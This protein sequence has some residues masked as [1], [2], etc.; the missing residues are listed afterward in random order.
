M[1]EDTSTVVRAYRERLLADPYRPGYHFCVPDGDGRPGDPN[2]CFY[3]DGRHH[4]MYLYKRDGWQY[5]WGHVSSIDLVHW[6]H[7]PDA[8]RAEAGDEGCFSGGAFVDDDG[9][10]YLSFWIYNAQREEAQA[11]GAGIG[12]ACSTPPYDEWTRMEHVAI[13]STRWGIREVDGQPVGCADPSNIWKVNGVYYIQTGNLLVLD[14]CGRAPDSPATM[15]GDWTELF[16]SLDL[17][18]WT[19][20]GRFYTRRG[21]NTWTAEDED[22][23]CP[24]FLP[25][26]SA[27]EG[28]R[29]SAHYLQLFISHNRGAQYYI[30]RYDT[31]FFSPVVHGRM[32]WTDSAFFA[33][34]AYLDDQG[35]QIMFAWLR[36]NLPDD[37]ER[38]GW[39]GVQSLP[40]VL[41]AATDGTLRMRYAPEV[42]RLGYH[43]QEHAP[44]TLIAGR[45]PV[46]TPASCHVS[47]SA[48]CDAGRVGIRWGSTGG[49]WIGYDAALGKLVVAAETFR[50][51]APFTLA[52]GEPL[53]LDIF[54]DQSVI[55][56]FANDRQ[57]IT[58]RVYMQEPAK[59][60]LYLAGNCPVQKLTTWDMMPSMPY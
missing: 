22:D 9:T 14:A 32:T 59:Q 12:I 17:R 3:A 47:L 8:L 40:R 29:P 57:A 24:S 50:E 34:E 43:R 51:E 53:T 39:S 7:H 58:R 33:P 21:D 26:P 48:Y 49:V 15:R 19:Y 38:F 1:I 27:A 37:Y 31:P 42:E 11:A 55:E 45:V 44:D 30:G 46:G 35:R 60:Q 56:V 41:W 36:D 4:L 52:E 13:P 2:G 20:E 25:L 28:G 10:A 5:C 16:S 54:I 6:R 23:M 18:K